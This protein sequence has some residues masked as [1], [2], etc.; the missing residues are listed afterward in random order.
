VQTFSL[1][2]SGKVSPGVS[3]ESGKMARAGSKW[4][5]PKS[6][7][8]STDGTDPGVGLKEGTKAIGLEIAVGPS[9]SGVVA[10]RVVQTPKIT[11]ATK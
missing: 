6:N 8:A 10:K 1:V 9:R 7:G 2:A 5:D 3:L 4:S 11:P